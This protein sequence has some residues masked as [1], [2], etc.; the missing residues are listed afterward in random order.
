MVTKKL[1][2]QKPAEGILQMHNWGNTKTY[3]VLCSCGDDE[4]NHSI[5]VEQDDMG[6]VVNVYTQVRSLWWKANRFRTIWTLLTRGYVEYETSLILTEQQALNY[7]E[8][9]KTAINNVQTVK[10]K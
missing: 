4:H 8:T 9:L 7:A 2:A 6:V 3:K 10:H 1:T 5:W